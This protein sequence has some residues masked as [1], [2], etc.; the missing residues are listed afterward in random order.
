MS[1]TVYVT[2]ADKRKSRVYHTRDCGKGPANPRPIDR[3][4]AEAWGL[5][6]CGHCAGFEQRD[7]DHSIYQQ[8]VAYDG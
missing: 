3:D 1:E 8:A 7:P 2:P 6:E 4:T 5:R